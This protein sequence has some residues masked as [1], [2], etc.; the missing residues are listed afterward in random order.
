MTLLQLLLLLLLTTTTTTTHMWCFFTTYLLRGR[1]AQEAKAQLDKM[2]VY[3][4]PVLSTDLQEGSQQWTEYVVALDRML[5]A[6]V[7]SRSL[8]LLEVLFPVIRE[9][10]HRYA[11]TINLSLQRFLT[12]LNDEASQ[13][14][15]CIALSV[16][17]GFCARFILLSC[18]FLTSC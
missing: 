4:F 16:E 17:R 1:Y 14:R 12:Q 13:V 3:D 5:A 7:R 8:L 18:L 2:V 15:C 11:D 10:D 9:R 6:L